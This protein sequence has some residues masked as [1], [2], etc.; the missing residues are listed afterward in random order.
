MLRTSLVALCLMLLPAAAEAQQR[1]VLGVQES[2]TVQWELAAIDALGLDDRHGIE[3]ELR[4]VADSRAGQIA[5]Q[6][7]AV[8]V[9][10]SDF[11][12]VSV[13]R[14][15]GNPVTMVP[16]SLAVG[17]LMVPSGSGLAGVDDLA[18]TTIGVAGGPADK[19]WVVLQA[20]Y[21][22]RTGGVLAEDASARYGAPPLI[23]E[24]LTAGNIEA[25]LNF[26]QW[27]ARLKATGLV[28]LISVADMLRELG[29]SEPPPL[30]GWTF[31]ETTAEQ[32]P[33]ALARFLEASFD[34]KQALAEDDAVWPSLA[35]LMGA[36]DDPAL[37]ERL[38]DDYRAG[39][40]LRYAPENTAAAEQAYQLLARQGGSDIVADQP[41]LAPG[42][43]WPGFRR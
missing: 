38:R 19:S 15:S 14:G 13:Q 30:L 2:G 4:Y 35:E 10:L 22:D 37:F 36:A 40:V 39:I 20:Y 7:G 17:G 26:W 21:A 25:G 8:D 41:T 1:L 34:A 12:W 23:N 28:E 32:K 5:L 16:H 27:N 29:V 18:G 3:I 9:I 6:S 11:V 42:T 43:F 33:E 31:L 24:L